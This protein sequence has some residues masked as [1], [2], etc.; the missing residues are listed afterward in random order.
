[1]SNSRLPYSEQVLRRITPGGIVFAFASGMIAGGW[2]VVFI[3][4]LFIK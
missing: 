1:M 2:I 4:P 3:L